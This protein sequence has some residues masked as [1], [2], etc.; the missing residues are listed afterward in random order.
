MP[1]Y[2]R[3]KMKQDLLARTKEAYDAKD[4]ETSSRHFDTGFDIPFWRPGTTKGKPHIIDVIPFIAGPNF[5]TKASR[6]VAEGDWVYVL[7]LHVHKKVGPGKSVVVCP[8]KNY[9]NPCP[10]CEDIE[11]Q[12]L[13]GVEYE[14]IP[15]ASKI[16]CTYNVLVMDDSETESKGVQV[17]DVSWAYSAKC[18]DPL[19]QSRAGGYIPFADPDRTLGRSIA[20]EVGSDKYKKITG[21]RFELRDYDIPQEIL[22]EAFPLDTMIK[23]YTYQ[24]LAVIMWGK[25]GKPATVALPAKS[26]PEEAPAG[27]RLIRGG[28]AAG[29]APAPEQSP[30]SGATRT[31]KRTTV[32]EERTE[33]CPIGGVFATEFDK[34]GECDACDVKQRCAEAADRNDAAA[35]GLGGPVETAAQVAGP[36]QQAQASPPAAQPARRTLLRRS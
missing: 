5:P 16:Q 4:G 17:W 25:D 28:D 6:P 2:D 32:T 31:L 9:G 20:F 30:V 24:E 26:A 21:H 36:A 8:A 15:Y 1:V 10:I 14:D 33:T 34:Y 19:M 7:K 23:I 35:K 12:I 29:P 3:E 13:Q 27:R 18:I 11:E 22:D